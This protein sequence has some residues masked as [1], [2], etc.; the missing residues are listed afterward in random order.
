MEI[1]Q[2]LILGK[3]KEFINLIA[4]VIIGPLMLIITEEGFFRGW[5]W[6][7]FR[8]AGMAT[9]K[10]LFITTGLFSYLAY[11]NCYI[12]NGI[13]FTNYPSTHIFNK[14]SFTQF[15]QRDVTNG[16]RIGS[17]LLY[18]MLFGTHLH[19]DYWDLEKKSVHWVLQ[20]LFYQ[21]RK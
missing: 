4:G 9:S 13:R 7:A 18:A 15:N 16:F 12:R 14:C 5:L 1:F 11:F 20:I 3:K 17:F 2:L 8:K 21:I 19:M 10:T 6:G